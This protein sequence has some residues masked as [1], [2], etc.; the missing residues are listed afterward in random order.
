[1]KTYVR[2]NGEVIENTFKKIEETSI[3]LDRLMETF[4]GSAF[5]DVDD[6]LLYLYRLKENMGTRYNR[7][8]KKLRE[9]VKQQGLTLTELSKRTGIGLAMLSQ[10]L[11]CRR[12]WTEKDKD[13]ILRVLKVDPTPAN[14]RE[15]FD[16]QEQVLW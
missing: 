5:Q 4:N 13:V 1:M 6:I 16:G 9:I 7:Q 14:I 3:M 12:H 8:H 15:L 2:I 10:K 11:N